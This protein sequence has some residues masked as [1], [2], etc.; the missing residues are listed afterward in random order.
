MREW[1][2][3]CTIIDLG[4]RWKWVVNFSPGRFTSWEIASDTQG[5]AEV[6]ESQMK[7][8]NDD[9]VYRNL[10]GGEMRWFVENDIPLERLRKTRSPS[11]WSV[12]HQRFESVSPDYMSRAA[13]P[14]KLVC[15]ELKT[16]NWLS[17]VRSLWERHICFQVDQLVHV[18]KREICKS[19]PQSVSF[20]LQSCAVSHG[21]RSKIKIQCLQP[22]VLSRAERAVQV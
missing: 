1:R 8:K 13:T 16:G 18:G 19:E 12:G 22:S 7:Q 14:H 9:L 17:H 21:G 15:S 20:W 5:I 6:I 11:W 10:G 2:Y 4:T 3:N